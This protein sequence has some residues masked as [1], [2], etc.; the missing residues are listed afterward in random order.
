MNETERF[1]E[2]NPYL[3]RNEQILSEMRTLYKEVNLGDEVG[4]SNRFE[5][6]STGSFQSRTLNTE[7][8]IGVKRRTKE[9]PDTDGF[10]TQMR[11]IQ[12]LAIISAIWKNFPE[13]VNQLPAFYG[14]L[15]NKTGIAIG[16]ITE[17]FSQGGK[18]HVVNSAYGSYE[19]KDIFVED[20]V[21]DDEIEHMG[22]TVN[23]KRRLGDFWPMAKWKDRDEHS[24]RFGEDLIEQNLH[25]HSFQLSNDL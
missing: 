4:S 22:F 5:F 20:S 10:M 15:L 8:F 16:M 3:I 6:F 18:F 11:F 19:I 12:E 25:Q 9:W 23:G 7:L 17:D 13:F 21:D 1:Y 14:L 24:H 2:P